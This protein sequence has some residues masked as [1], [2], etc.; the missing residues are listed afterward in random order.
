MTYSVIYKKKLI[1]E[2]ILLG[3][4]CR[5]KNFY[6]IGQGLLLFHCWHGSDRTEAVAAMYRMAFQH[7]PKQQAIDEMV[8]GIFSFHMIFDNIINT[9]EE[10]NIRKSE[11]Y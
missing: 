4:K 9:I 6:R 3:H 1:A 2:P 5:L 11:E 7:I 10:A 8:D